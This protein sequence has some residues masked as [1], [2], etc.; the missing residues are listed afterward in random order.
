MFNPR[1]D[2]ISHE[3]AIR[4]SPWVC[5]SPRSWLLSLSLAVTAL[6]RE[7]RDPLML[8]SPFPQ[9][10]SRQGP[11]TTAFLQGEKEK[12]EIDQEE[13]KEVRVLKTDETSKTQGQ[14]KEQNRGNN[15][16]ESASD[17]SSGGKCLLC[18]LVPVYLSTLVPRASPSC[19]F[20]SPLLQMIAI[21]PTS[22]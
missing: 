9:C 20:C 12:E 18:L 16:L 6:T 1:C 17:S 7:P 5:E 8:P 13:E 19:A 15:A 2:R 14:G 10:L 4:C 21:I 3:V 22:W 11:D